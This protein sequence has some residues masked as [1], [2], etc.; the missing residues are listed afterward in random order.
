MSATRPSRM[1]RA[2]SLRM[3]IR[4]RSL[5]LRVAVYGILIGKRLRPS[6]S[7]VVARKAERNIVDDVLVHGDEHNE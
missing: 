7:I 5:R 4:L 1:M 6:R 3:R 2:F